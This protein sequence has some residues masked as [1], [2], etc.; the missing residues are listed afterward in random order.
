MKTR[1]K[2]A[3]VRLDRGEYAKLAKVRVYL[4]CIDIIYANV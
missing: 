4:G 3:K 2:L 1:L